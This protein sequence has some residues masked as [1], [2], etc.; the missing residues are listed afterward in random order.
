MPVVPVVPGHVFGGT[1][2]FRRGIVNLRNVAVTLLISLICVACAGTA[3]TTSTSS[4]V[5]TST[6]QT[7]AATTTTAPPAT[8]AATSPA[9]PVTEVGDG[10]VRESDLTYMT[11]DGFDY[12]MDV[13][14]PDSEGPW[15]VAVVF[16]GLDSEGK[17]GSDQTVIAEGAVANGFLVFVPSWLGSF[18][19]DLATWLT[20]K[21][22]TGCAVAFAQDQASERG[23]DPA[24]TVLYGFSAGVGG[25]LWATLE[26]IE[27]PISG[28]L[29]DATSV[30]PRGIVLG[31]GDVLLM[32][33]PWDRVFNI[34]PEAMPDELAAFY[35]PARWPADLSARVFL[36][37]AANGSPPS[38]SID[39]G[40]L[41][42]RDP[43]GSLRADL[44]AL[45]LLDDGEVSTADAGR[46]LAM[47]MTDGGLDVTIDQYPGGHRV[48][49]KVDELVEYIVAAA[50]D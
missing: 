11:V 27:D 30:Q 48:D 43:D 17:D 16:H 44:E 9:P 47:H 1:G 20:W 45:G 38:R 28:C 26:P 12:L 29:T 13:Y 7:L 15:P 34:E 10:Y 40:W 2:A 36:W 23:G 6:T 31:D 21:Q 14:T 35:D 39:S 42:K 32:G 19:L 8:T 46:L 5:A 24:N 50:A 49:D 37:V 4:P 22:V 33:S 3:E 25:P 41:D 18:S